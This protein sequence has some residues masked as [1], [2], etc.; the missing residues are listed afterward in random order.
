VAGGEWRVASGKGLG[1]LIIV[2][3]APL[4]AD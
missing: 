2:P 1:A 4:A 3:A